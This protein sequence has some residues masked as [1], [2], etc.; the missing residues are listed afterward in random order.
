MT[1]TVLAKRGGTA[2]SIGS[3][4]SG[5]P[6]NEITVGPGSGTPS[7]TVPSTTETP[8]SRSPISMR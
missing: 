3:H 7:T 1:E 6:D 4:T 5:V 2:R 8:V